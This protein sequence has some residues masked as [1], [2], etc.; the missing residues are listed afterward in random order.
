MNV[1]EPTVTNGTGSAP[2]VLSA[3]ILTVPNLITAARLAC[4]PVFVWLLLVDGNRIGAA[5]LLGGLGATDWVD[6][7]LARRLDQRS[8]FGAKFDPTVDRVLFIVALGA[9][10][11]DGSIPV[12]FA[13]AVLVR[14]VIVGGSVALATM[15]LSMRRFDVTFWGKTATFLLMFAVPGFVLAESSILGADG[16]GLLAWMLGIP[17]VV[18]SYA[19]GVSYFPKIIEG[20]RAARQ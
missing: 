4:V 3:A 2:E 17:G 1:D 12:V 7:Y 15:L 16:F 9:I 18:L 20:V 14:E 8:E 11:V 6:G 13:V 10:L 19:T 5:F